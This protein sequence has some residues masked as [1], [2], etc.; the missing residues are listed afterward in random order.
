MDDYALV[1]NAGS[2]SLKFCVY[3]RAP[4]ETWRLAAR[5]Q[6]EGIG[7]APR[8]SA[9]DGEGRPLV[10]ESLD[11]GVQDG[12]AAIESLATWLRARWAGARVLGVGHRVV[13]GGP[14]F[15]GPVVIDDPV[16]AELRAL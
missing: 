10:D 4:R 13:H 14:R 12:H 11:A 8:L 1:L 9:K 16:M 3:A 6:V 5:G 2:S 7:S 15:A